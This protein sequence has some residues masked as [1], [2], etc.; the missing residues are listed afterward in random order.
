MLPHLPRQVNY[1]SQPAAHPL[2]F[3]AT[4]CSTQ[5][6]VQ[7]IKRGAELEREQNFQQARDECVPSALLLPRTLFLSIL[8]LAINPLAQP[9]LEQGRQLL[10]RAR[11]TPAS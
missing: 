1:V 3:A 7:L 2:A 9:S 8:S 5:V 6:G 4:H 10:R 11:H